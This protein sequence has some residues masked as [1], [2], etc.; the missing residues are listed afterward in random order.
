ME[1]D[2]TRVVSPVRTVTRTTPTPLVN[3][4]TVAGS[5]QS[6]IWLPRLTGIRPAP[7][8][9]SPSTRTTVCGKAPSRSR[10]TGA[11]YEFKV[12]INDCWDINYGAGGAAGGENIPLTSAARHHSRHLR[13]GSGVAHRDPHAEQLKS[14]P[15]CKNAGGIPRRSLLLNGS[16]WLCGADARSCGTPL[17]RSPLIF[18]ETAPDTMIL[19]SFQRP[20]QAC[21]PDLTSPADLLGLFY[22][23]K[24]R[25][26]IPNWEE[27]LR[28]LVQASGPVA[29]IHWRYAPNWLLWA[30]GVGPRRMGK[31]LVLYTEA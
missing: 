22:L 28:V 19:T 11:D 15:A 31:R 23:E 2:G 21:V 25:A 12:A 4:V 16:L 29:P 27:Q 1:P 13:L 10:S 18:A 14:G 9:T 24:G 6:E 3:N 5:L 7:P 20:L 30:L 17:Q 26:G 8:A